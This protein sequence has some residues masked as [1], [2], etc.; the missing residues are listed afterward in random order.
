[1][2]ATYRKIY[3]AFRKN[4]FAF[5][6]SDKY[7]LQFTQIHFAF[8]TLS[9]GTGLMGGSNSAAFSFASYC[10]R[11][12]RRCCIAS[13]RFGLCVII[14]KVT[15]DSFFRCSYCNSIILQVVF[16]CFCKFIPLQVS[17]YQHRS[18]VFQLVQGYY[19]NG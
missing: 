5:C 16:L 6:S 7:I 15:F 11:P 3:F 1:M 19:T 9:G 13:L 10:Q 18:T 4:A 2:G 12:H 17:H 14:P 8:H